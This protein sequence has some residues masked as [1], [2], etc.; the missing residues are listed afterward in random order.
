[1]TKKRE[2]EMERT[3]EENGESRRKR[4]IDLLRHVQLEKVGNVI[5]D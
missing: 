1:M 3:S 2:R 5:G 4:Y